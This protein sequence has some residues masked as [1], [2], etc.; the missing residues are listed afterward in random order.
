MI[1]QILLSVALIILAWSV[2]SLFAWAH[3]MERGLPLDRGDID[4]SR[5]AKAGLDVEF[6]ALPLLLAFAVQLFGLDA[7]LAAS[8]G[9]VLSICLLSIGY[10]VL[11][12]ALLRGWLTELRLAHRARARQRP[13][14]G[15]AGLAH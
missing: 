4:V 3:G 14:G 11:Y 10:V 7:T 8:A 9:R 1:T 13:P 15:P 5:L 6:A 2:L 12:F